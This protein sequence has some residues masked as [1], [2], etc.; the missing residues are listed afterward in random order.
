MQRHRREHRKKNASTQ[1]S[2]F[3]HFEYD[4]QHRDTHTH[5]HIF[6][7]AFAHDDMIGERER[8]EYF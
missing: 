7:V 1:A 5:P 2:Y 4:D 6:V 8:N 3:R